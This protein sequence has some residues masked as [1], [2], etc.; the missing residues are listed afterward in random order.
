MNYNS[1]E[2]ILSAGTSN[3]TVI[4]NNTKQDDGTDTITGVS[5]FTFNGVTASNFKESKIVI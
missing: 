4:R 2:E 5:W 1:I 3:M